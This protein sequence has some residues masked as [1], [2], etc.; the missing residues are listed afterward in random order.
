[1]KKASLRAVLAVLVAC[2][3]SLVIGPA[4]AR[5]HGCE[6]GLCI[7]GQGACPV[8]GQAGPVFVGYGDDASALGNGCAPPD[9]CDTKLVLRGAASYRKGCEVPVR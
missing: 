2:S 6:D 9:R 8:E 5:A 3:G 1:M 7:P 4:P